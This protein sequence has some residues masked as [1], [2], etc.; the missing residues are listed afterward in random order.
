MT[1]TVKIQKKY[2]FDASHMLVG[3]EGKCRNNHGHTY[4]IRVWLK[5]EVYEGAGESDDQMLLDYGALDQIVKP[6]VD[7]MDHAYLVGDMAGSME[8]DLVA[9]CTEYDCKLYHVGARTTAENLAYHI[10]EKV[11]GAI[12]DAGYVNVT[13]AGVIVSETPKTRAEYIGELK[14]AD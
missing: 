13:L 4:T 8:T 3:H 9:W 2:T 14:H 7:E 11:A 1:H 10:W 6:L 5:G 12:V